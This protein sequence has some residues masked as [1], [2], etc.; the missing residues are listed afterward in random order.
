MTALDLLTD[1]DRARLRRAAAPGWRAPMLATLIDEPFSHDEWIF[2]RKLDGVRA[3]S[4]SDESGPVLW[5]RNRNTMNVSYPE[6]ESALRGHAREHL[7]VDG[8]IVAFHGNQTSFEQ[9]QRRIHLTDRRRIAASDVTVY[10][11]LFDILEYAGQDLTRIPLRTRKRVLQHAVEFTDPIRYS[12]H[13]NSAGDQSYRQACE[14]G[15][16][17]VIAKRA[18][19]PY[20]HGRSRDWLKCKCTA[21][22]EL[23]VGG[24]TDPHG[25]RR[26]FGALLVGYYQGA[27]LRYAGKVG[28]G[29]DEALLRSLRAKLDG[30]ET[31]SRPFHERV[32]EHGAHWVEPR[33]VAEVAFSEWTHD[34]K[35]RHPRFQGLRADK[36]AK[37][38][39]RESR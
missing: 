29:Y 2:E 6:L 13:R 21:S 31:R 26:G 12:P 16:E 37:E 18:A 33:L 11:Y 30:L 3:V 32:S 1:A 17:G 7:V 38:V 35:L 39:V 15:W 19:A 27:E 36:D 20:Q 25:A 14:R 9:L 4:S 28:T 23:V 10:Y 22:Q 24:F 5:S 8:E 34:G